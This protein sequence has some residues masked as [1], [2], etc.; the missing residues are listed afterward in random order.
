MD[1]LT[2]ALHVR[3][4]NDGTNPI[5]TP[6]Y[7]CSAFS[8][9]SPYFYT[10]KDNP[11]VAELESVLQVLEGADFAIAVTCGMAAIYMTLDLLA[12]GDLVILNRDVYGCSYRL[13]ERLAKKR[14][15]RVEILDLADPDTVS[16]LP[17]DARMVFFETP[18]NPFLKTINISEVAKRAKAGNP[19]CLVVVDNTW[20]TPLFQRPLDLG[21]DISIHSGTKYLSGHS[22]VMNGALLTNDQSLAEGLFQT[23]FYGGFLLSPESAWLVRRSLQTLEI[24][25]RHQE[26]TARKMA[27]FL[28]QRP[29][30]AQVYYPEIDGRQLTGYGGIIFFR[31][32]QDLIHQ[33]RAFTEHLELFDTGTGMACVTSMVAQPYSGSHASLSAEEK[34]S[35][36]LGEDLVRLCFGLEAFVDLRSD[37]QHALESLAC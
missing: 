17:S 28:R 26:K 33:Y 24:R 1:H 3:V 32:R 5:V 20:A 2:R 35:I 12:P 9:D 19:D 6:V 18:T 8:A 21:A 11:N 29:E 30:V 15:F 36:G 13:F 10:R 16:S 27:D 25:L 4:N 23:R 22:D 14:Q 37:L 7:Q 34:E 31:L